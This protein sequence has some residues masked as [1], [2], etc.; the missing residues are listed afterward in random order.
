VRGRVLAREKSSPSVESFNSRMIGLSELGST[1]LD[2][3]CF[4]PVG[5]RL[6]A[7]IELV[8]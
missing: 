4:Q 8:S 5:N 1:Q 6:P 2:A 3:L 7:D